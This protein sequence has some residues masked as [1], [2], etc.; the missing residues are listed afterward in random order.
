MTKQER[1]LCIICRVYEKKLKEVLDQKDFNAIQMES[2]RMIQINDVL[3]EH[4][5]D[6]EFRDFL[7]T[8]IDPKQEELERFRNFLFTWD[9]ENHPHDYEDPDVLKDLEDDEPFIG[10]DGEETDFL[11]PE[12]IE[13]LFDDE[14]DDYEDFCASCGY[15]NANDDCCEYGG[16]HC[17]QEEKKGE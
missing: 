9:Y 12:D 15:Y 11:E 13:T 5:E 4:M 2:F 10:P 3:N 14:D 8:M 17:I 7:W 6:S 1:D 16:N